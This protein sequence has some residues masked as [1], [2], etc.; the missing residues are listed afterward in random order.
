MPKDDEL[1]MGRNLYEEFYVD[2]LLFVPNEFGDKKIEKKIIQ[3]V[4]R[5]AM[6]NYPFNNDKTSMTFNFLLSELF[7]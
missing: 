5:N 3:I 6:N 2:K 4:E 7:D 1:L